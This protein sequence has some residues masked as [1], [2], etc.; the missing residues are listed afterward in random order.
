L[1]YAREELGQGN[2]TLLYGLQ[3]HCIASMLAKRTL[4]L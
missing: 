3:N 4:L 2:R 1:S